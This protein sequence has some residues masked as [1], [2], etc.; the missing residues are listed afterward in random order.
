MKKLVALLIWLAVSSVWA[1]ETSNLLT[2]TWSGTVN[3]TGTG[4]GTSGGYTPGYNS[5]NN[6]IY[7]GYNQSTVAQTIAINNAL[8]G[9]GVQVG[10]I[11]YGF[12]Y[13]N[14]GEYSGTLST[15]I[16]VT[17]NTGVTLQTYSHNHGSTT[18]WGQFNQVQTF[19]NPYT[20]ANLGNVSMSITGKDNRF[21]AGYYGP[22][23]KDPYL[24]LTYT[25][26]TIT[27]P[28]FSDDSYVAVPLQFGFPFYGRTFTNSWMHSNGVVSFLDPAV[29]IAGVG[30]NP[31]FNAYCCGDRPTGTKPEFSFIIAPLWTDLYPVP[32][33]TFRTEGTTTYQKYF[34]NNISEISN[35]NNLNTFSLEI[36][37]S[38]FIGATYDKINIQNQN[39]WA[40]IVG[41]P[42][43]GQK[44][45][46]AHV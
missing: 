41:D 32:S 27:N 34:W 43:L 25:A 18:N 22:Q 4:A 12:S 20:L 33:S 1:E 6:T 13:F 19:T 5:S 14:S 39:T 29:P 7:F 8:Q 36:R 2:N 3:Y 17:S 40:G 42:A 23:V 26:A 37:P 16:N 9:S 46:R 15:T 35:G 28:T 11:K 38:G 21:W 44:I 45:G 30:Y 31:G 10:G 24:N